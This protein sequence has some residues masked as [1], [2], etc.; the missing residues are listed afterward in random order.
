MEFLELLTLISNPLLESPIDVSTT[1]LP[2]DCHL[3][4]SCCPKLLGLKTIFEGSVQDFKQYKDEESLQAA[5][6]DPLMNW[7]AHS[8]EQQWM[9]VRGM[10]AQYEDKESLQ[11]TLTDPLMVWPAQSSE[12]ERMRVQGMMAQY[13]DDESFE[14]ALTDPLVVWLLQSS[15]QGWMHVQGMM[16][17]YEVN[18]HQ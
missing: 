9:R 4:I 2:N 8:S 7:L 16:A 3:L 10:M 17:Q 14:A 1:K 5:L 13:E 12:Q 15:K 18:S 6:T 11:A